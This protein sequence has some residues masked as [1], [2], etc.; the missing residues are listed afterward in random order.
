MYVC[1]LQPKSQKRISHVALTAEY[2][3][4]S[5]VFSVDI[6]ETERNLLMVCTPPPPSHTSS[7]LPLYSPPT[8]LPFI[9][10]PHLLSPPS[11]LYSPPLPLPFIPQDLSIFMNPSPYT[12]SREAPLPQVFN[13]FR[14][15]G[16]RHLPVMQESGI[17]STRTCTCMW[18]ACDMHVACM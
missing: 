10:H 3:R 12:I 15:M 2:P 4:Y 18:H 11:P 9:P 14:T 6:S 13:L 7:P 5:D 16:L 8:P 17:V 1:T